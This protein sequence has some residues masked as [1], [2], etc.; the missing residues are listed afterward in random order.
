MLGKSL[1]VAAF[2]LFAAHA[3]ATAGPNRPS[4]SSGKLF[5]AQSGIV[6]AMQARCAKAKRRCMM[7]CPYGNSSCMAN[8]MNYHGC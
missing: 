4:S 1:L 8:C 5:G 6:G 3:S 7:F 2:V